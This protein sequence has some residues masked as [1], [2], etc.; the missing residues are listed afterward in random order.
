[1]VYILIIYAVSVHFVFTQTIIEKSQIEKLPIEII[2]PIKSVSLDKNAGRCEFIA[3]NKYNKMV[4]IVDSFKHKIYIYTDDLNFSNSFGAF[5]QGP[6]EFDSPRSITFL[7]NGNSIISD[8][9]NY[10][11]IV[12]DNNYNFVVNIPFPY[13]VS[14]ILAFVYIRADS[15]NRIYLN[16]ADSSSGSIFTIK[17][18]DGSDSLKWGNMF[19]SNN[20]IFNY[21]DNKAHFVLDE[22]DNLYCAFINKPYMQ[23]YDKDGNVIF[24]YDCS[25]FPGADSMQKKWETKLKSD[26]ILKENV[27]ASK[28]YLFKNYIKCISVDD[29][30]L[31]ILFNGEKNDPLYVFNKIDGKL[32]KKIIIEEKSAPESSILFFDFS[33]KNNLYIIRNNKTISLLNK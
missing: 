32:L 16:F 13:Q 10:R 1:M 9:N 15:R 2:T 26:P 14:T 12:Y 5:G 33:D 31:Y 30:F 18:I 7:T 22:K 25:F 23:K 28:G 11:Y 20:K 29:K 6:G 3:Y 8:M 21:Y 4:Y 19:S 24:E 27:L 17:T